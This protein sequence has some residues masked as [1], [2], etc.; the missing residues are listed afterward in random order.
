[1]G[2]VNTLVCMDVRGPF[3]VLVRSNNLSAPEREKN[4]SPL[5]LERFPHKLGEPWVDLDGPKVLYPILSE[6]LLK[7]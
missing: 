5:P 2:K 4:Y 7:L 3:H 6:I 1:M